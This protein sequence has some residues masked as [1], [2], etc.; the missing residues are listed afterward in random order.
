MSRLMLLLLVLV[1]A[2]PLGGCKL[3]RR[4]PWAGKPLPPLVA[5]RDVGVEHGLVRRILALPLHDE[6]GQGI[7]TEVVSQALRDEIA[8][9]NR[10]SLVRP[11]SSDARLMPSEGPQRTGRIPVRSLINLGRRYG[12]DAVMYGSVKRYR[13]YSPP[14]LG[15][16]VQLIDIET[17][18]V[19]WSAQELLDATDART[20]VS[21]RYFFEDETAADETVFDYDIMST[22]PEWFAKFAAHRIAATL[23]PPPPPK[24]G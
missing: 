9:L 17:G 11:N 1:S 2:L 5:F 16:I 21:M 22:S 7:G 20:A 18:K 19:V 23:L 14:V 8:K 10:F 4:A 24:Q 6:S 3:L 15:M 12:V 13:P